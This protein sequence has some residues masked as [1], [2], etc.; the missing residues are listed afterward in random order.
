MELRT[1][2]KV[3]PLPLDFHK[4]VEK[5]R[6]SRIDRARQLSMN[7]EM[8]QAVLHTTELYNLEAERQRLKQRRLVRPLL[9]SFTMPRWTP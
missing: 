5:R 4:E 7:V 2:P 8:Q 1:V 3:R 9:E 6:Q